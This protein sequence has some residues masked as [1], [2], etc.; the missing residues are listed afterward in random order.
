M[1]LIYLNYLNFFYKLIV[2]I[3]NIHLFC[4]FFSEKSELF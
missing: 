3:K 2:K 1:Y 4:I